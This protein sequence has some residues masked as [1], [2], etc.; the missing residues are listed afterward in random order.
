[1]RS[2]RRVAHGA[3]KQPALEP[4]GYSRRRPEGTALYGAVRLHMRAFLDGL[5]EESAGLPAHVQREL[6]SYLRCGILA[7]GFVRVWCPTCKDDLLVGFS[8]QGRGI[9]PSCGGRRMA[10]TAARWVDRV[11]PGVPWRQWVL[12]VPFELR[13]W[14]A[15]NPALMTDVLSVFQR[16]IRRRL[17]LMA[18]AMGHRGGQH[19]SVT[20][21][22]RFGSALNLNVHLHSLVAE[23]VWVPSK[24]DPDRP[25]WV[26]LRLGQDDVAAVLAAVDVEVTRLLVER[27]LL[28]E[29]EDG[30]VP[31]GLPDGDPDR[32][33]E[34]GLMRASIALRVA[35]GPRAGQP[36]RRV[37]AP[38]RP[39]KASS[40]GRR[41]RMHARSGAFDLHA[42]V[43]VRRSDRQGLER[44]GRYLLRP[45]IATDRLRL[46]GDGRYEYGLRR[47]W[48]DGTTALLFDP[49]E[50]MEKLAALVPIP[51]ANLVRYHGVL[52]P[53]ANWR[54][55]VIPQADEEDRIC[56][57]R[58]PGGRVPKDRTPWSQLL[59]RAF[60]VQVLRCAR[61]GNARRILAEVTEP[62]AVKGILEHLGLPLDTEGPVPTRGP[63]LADLPWAS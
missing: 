16:A 5:D 28:A 43:L 8:C 32:A 42:A 57:H 51:R 35:T 31:L 20:V 29:D 49:H 2:Q 58:A 47:A 60:R 39:L 6:E 1:M 3:R 10:D 21:V 61:C 24:A 40:E 56:G 41:K 9:C 62:D 30:D 50:L 12:T 63:P 52:A 19:A 7:H 27:G 38:S 59:R 18:R 55:Y 54:R 26:P 33:V 14:M 44:L 22:Q 45:A 36:V 4:P 34:L 53:A 48:S 13:L 23:G 15:W 46:R 11:L 17:R 25:Q 37:G